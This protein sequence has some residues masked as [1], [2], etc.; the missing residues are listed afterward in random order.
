VSPLAL[1]FHTPAFGMRDSRKVKPR[2][3][4]DSIFVRI[5]FSLGQLVCPV[6]LIFLTV[7]RYLRSVWQGLFFSPSKDNGPEVLR[8]SLCPPHVIHRRFSARCPPG[9]VFLMGFS[10]F[11][12]GELIAMN[13]RPEAFH[14]VPARRLISRSAC[15]MWLPLIFSCVNYLPR[16]FS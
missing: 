15:F 14:P 5:V 11:T 6:S 16:S 12:S 3:P 4:P 7:P 2:A 9:P 10:A 8:F 13:V 1:Y